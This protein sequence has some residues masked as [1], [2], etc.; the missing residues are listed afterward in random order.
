LYD[1]CDIHAAI[2]N[3][4]LNA[5][6]L[7]TTNTLVRAQIVYLIFQKDTANE[8]NARVCS[9]SHIM[10]NELNYGISALAR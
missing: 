6:G 7:I 4:A 2:I 8:Q 3:P 1:E 10:T 9:V 5:A